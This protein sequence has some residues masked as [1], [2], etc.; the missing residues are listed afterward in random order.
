MAN[1]KFHISAIFKAYDK[2]SGPVAKMQMSMTRFG[3]TMRRTLGGMARMTRRVVRG[4]KSMGL[5]IVGVGVVGGFALKHLLGPAARFEQAMAGVRAVTNTLTFQAMPALREEAK[6]LGRSTI[7]TA[8][9][10][11]EAMEIMGRAGLGHGEIKSGIE[12][13]L[14]AAEAEGGSIQETAKVIISS[15]KGMNIPFA[16][17]EMV[18][19]TFAIASASA[20]TNI[21]NLGEGLSKVAPVAKQFSMDFTE[22]VTAVA[23]LQDVGVEASMSGT[24]MKT[25]FTKL[26]KL[27]PKAT[28]EFRKFNI[29]ITKGN[30]GKDMK[31]TVDLIAAI[32]AGLD[33]VSGN[34]RKVKIIGEAV[35]LR[36]S[37]AANILAEAHR[38]GR[39][40]ELLRTIEKNREGAAKGMSKIRQDTLLGDITRLKSAYEGFRIDM[41]TDS[42]PAVRDVIQALTKFFQDEGNI[43]A[44]AEKFDNAIHGLR[45]FWSDNGEKMGLMFKDF[46]TASA[47]MWEAAK[48]LHSLTAWMIPD[49]GTDVDAATKRRINEFERTG[50]LPPREDGTD[51]ITVKHMGQVH[52]VDAKSGILYIKLSPD[53]K[54]LDD[55]TDQVV[56]GPFGIKL[57]VP[58]GSFFDSDA[59][60]AF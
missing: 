9:Q 19:N 52:D 51:P 29:E 32:A 26:A 10:V 35:G 44:A 24:Q 14:R 37:M 53:L 46:M 28:K 34:V 8:T 58:T 25:M 57:R 48:V 4:M 17:T 27:T 23:L 54:P 5:A 59:E 55:Q 11:G 3:K 39:M 60:P 7:F 12:P 21:I 40:A 43:K 36:G 2:F 41:A 49:V 47:L 16:E 22:V 50:V 56:T 42:L 15:M 6:R 30:K 18:A 38:T 20:K 33:K 1:Q 13:I 45:S 31:G